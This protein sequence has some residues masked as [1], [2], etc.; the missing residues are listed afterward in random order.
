MYTIIYLNVPYEDKEEAK[1]LGC[2]W[3]AK[4]K[5]WFIENPKDR[6]LYKKWYLECQKF[7]PKKDKNG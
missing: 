2:K 1:E 7:K 3:N 5:K 4:R 6:A